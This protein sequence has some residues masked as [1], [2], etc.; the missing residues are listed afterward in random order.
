MID[1]YIHN[2]NLNNYDYL[3][4]ENPPTYPDGMDVEVFKFK[5]LE[6]AYFNC[7]SKFEKEHV[8]PGIKNNKDIKIG[9]KIQK[10]FFFS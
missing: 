2:F 5:I 10:K 4:D 1:K 9:K 8:T 6:Y 7:K 3:S